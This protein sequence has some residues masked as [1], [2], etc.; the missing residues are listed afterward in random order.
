MNSFLL[1]LSLYIILDNVLAS[2]TRLPK[3][4]AGNWKMNPVDLKS[5][6]KLAF[7]V[8]KL[9]KSGSIWMLISPHFRKL[10]NSFTSL[11]WPKES[12]NCCNTTF[13]ISAGRFKDTWKRRT[14]KVGRTN[15]FFWAKRCFYRSCY[16]QYAGFLWREL[17][18]CWGKRRYY[19]CI[20]ELY[21]LLQISIH[22]YKSNSM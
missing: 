13:S 16:G 10:I 21:S 19:N 7:D 18:P 4:I 3:L 5:A 22:V 20:L 9:T 2:T 14:C 12:R 15:Q 17:C 6:T 11:S 1:F 8:A